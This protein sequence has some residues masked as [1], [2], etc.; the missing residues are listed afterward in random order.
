MPPI[1]AYKLG[2][3]YYVL[4]G[5]HRVAAALANGQVEIE[6][7]VVE[8]VPVSDEHAHEL[9]VARRAFEQATGLTDVGAARPETYTILRDTIQRFAAE[10]GLA[11]LPLAARRWYAEVFRPLWQAIRARELSGLC[12][13]DRTAD[14]IARLSAWRAAE[15]PDLDW[16][17]A[18]DAFVREVE[19]Q[20]ISSASSRNG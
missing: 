18:L 15:A 9:F 19:A 5:H 10:Q 3:G 1:D 2:F 4:D 6:A 8:H 12:P 17:A 7:N 14:L 16:M 11:E 20:P 13:A